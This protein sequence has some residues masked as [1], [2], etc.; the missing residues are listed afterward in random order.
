MAVVGCA[1]APHT[2]APWPVRV[3][4]WRDAPVPRA[5]LH[6]HAERAAPGLGHLAPASQ[7]LPGVAH[8]WG[9]PGWRP[10][11]VRAAVA[12]SRDGPTGW[13]W[14][15]PARHPP[16]GRLSPR[17]V[18]SVRPGVR[19]Q[20]GMAR[21]SGQSVSGRG[22]KSGAR[23]SCPSRVRRWWGGPGRCAAEPCVWSPPCAG[24][25]AAA[26]AIATLPG[27]SPACPGVSR[28]R[29]R[30]GAS[31]GRQARSRGRSGAEQGLAGDRQQPP[32]LRRSGS[33]RRLKP[34]VRLIPRRHDDTVWRKLWTPKLWR[35]RNCSH[36]YLG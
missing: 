20:Q 14:R 33:W 6:G 15:R 27:A 7:G 1:A 32:L 31:E 3:V 5:L 24:G 22:R 13:R 26:P 10:G 25:G 11:R 21:G 28:R 19:S 12:P 23:R 34:G 30:H 9:S 29:W 16:G 8:V 18:G 17:P 2:P 35:Q 36:F 4:R